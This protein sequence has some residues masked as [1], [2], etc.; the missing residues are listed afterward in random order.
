MI[1]LVF[2][3]KIWII[4]LII[5]GFILIWQ[6]QNISSMPNENILTSS[7]NDKPDHSYFAHGAEGEQADNCFLQ[8]GATK[9][10]KVME[11]DKRITYH[12]ICQDDLGNNYDFVMDEEGRKLTSFLPKDGRM[13][14]ILRWL[15]RKL[16]YKTIEANTLPETLLNSLREMKIPNIP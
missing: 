13:S 14:E 8:H 15:S 1:T 6:A 5:G 11:P 7:S 4:L 12:F 10:F 16:S 3:K 9:I 2:D